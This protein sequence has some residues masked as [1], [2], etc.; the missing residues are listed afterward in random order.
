MRSALKASLRF[1]RS[2]AHKKHVEAEIGASEDEANG[3]H[4]SGENSEPLPDAVPGASEV[5]MLG[6][7]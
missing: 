2:Q 5:K 4:F 7:A 1:M 6:I 3:T